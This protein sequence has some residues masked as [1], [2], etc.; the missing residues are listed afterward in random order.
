MNSTSVI[1]E[2]LLDPNVL[3]DLYQIFCQLVESVA[4][5]SFENFVDLDLSR[6]E[7][8]VQNNLK[9]FLRVFGGLLGKISGVSIDTFVGWMRG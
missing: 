8:R 7:E 9:D 3:D 5:I 1:N 2:I 6:F 4:Q